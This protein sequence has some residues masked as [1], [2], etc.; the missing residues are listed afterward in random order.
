MPLTEAFERILAEPMLSPED[1]PAQARS[2]MDGYAVR[3]ADT[4]GASESM[5]CYLN[6]TGEVQ[7]GAPPSGQKRLLL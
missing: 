5:P 7:M 6:I 2:T 1:L 3:A 4:F